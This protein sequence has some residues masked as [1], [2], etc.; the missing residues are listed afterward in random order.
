M[1][2]PPIQYPLVSISYCVKCNWVL[3]ASWYQQELLQTFTSKATTSDDAD[4]RSVLL[5]PSYIPGT[6]KV[7]VKKEE[8]AD[9][10]LVW[11]RTENGGFPDAKTLKQE[12]RN[13]VSPKKNLGH[14]DKKSVKGVLVSHDTTPPAPTRKLS[15][16]GSNPITRIKSHEPT[17][18]DLETYGSPRLASSH[19][20][21][22]EE[23]LDTL[24]PAWEM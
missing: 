1:E 16:Q 11:D 8:N 5:T 3:R 14:S 23:C 22:C 18:S 2:Q 17:Q 6:F 24:P 13:I 7:Y 4:I 20:T 10:I 19:K 15:S 12:I 21:F 9:W